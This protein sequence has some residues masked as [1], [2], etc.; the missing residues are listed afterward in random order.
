MGT[1]WHQDDDTKAIWNG[2]RSP[3]RRKDRKPGVE[4]LQI[5]I[6]VITKDMGKL[7]SENRLLREKALDFQLRAKKAEAQLR[8]EARLQRRGFPY[9]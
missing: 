9:Q 4:E 6:R 8:A 2:G 7:S 5:H 3:M 1:Q